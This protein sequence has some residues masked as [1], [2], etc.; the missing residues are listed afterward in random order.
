M[1]W[2]QRLREHDSPGLL[3][4]KAAIDRAQSAEAE[5]RNR[6]QDVFKAKDNADATSEKLERVFREN[7]FSKHMFHAMKGNH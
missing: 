4:A 5:A 7:G 1:R 2:F 6:W 3:E